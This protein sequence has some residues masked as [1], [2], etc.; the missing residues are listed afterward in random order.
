LP[1]PWNRESPRHRRRLIGPWLPSRRRGLFL[2]AFD[3]WIGYPSPNGKARFATGLAVSDTSKAL[4]GPGV[5]EPTT[6]E[7]QVR[8]RNHGPIDPV[9]V[10]LQ[11]STAGGCCL[12]R[13]CKD[14]QRSIH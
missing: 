5:P 8:F 9:T 4:F 7:V 10:H 2:S 11:M 14:Q 6:A 12:P 13:G 3:P 1:D